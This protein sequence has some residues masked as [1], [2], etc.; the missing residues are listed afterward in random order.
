MFWGCDPE[1]LRALAGDLLRDAG[2][3]A[4]QQSRL[5]TVIGTASWEGPDAGSW[6]ERALGQML[7]GMARESAALVQSAQQLLLHAQQQDEASQAA[8]GADDPPMAEA[9]VMTAGAAVAGAAG[10]STT[11]GSVETGS[12]PV[13]RTR[14]RGGAPPGLPGVAPLYPGASLGLAGDVVGPEY[15][16]AAQRLWLQGEAAGIR[17]GRRPI[18]GAPAGIVAGLAGVVRGE[19]ETG[20][21]LREG[22]VFR[23][24][25]G[26]LTMAISGTDGLMNAA[27]LTPAAPV[28]T[29]LSRVTGAISGFWNAREQ[30]ALDQ[31]AAG[32][33]PDGSVTRMLWELP[34]RW[35]EDLIQPVAGQIGGPLGERISELSGR[36]AGF[37]RGV[38]SLV[39]AG[40]RLEILRF[41]REHPL[42]VIGL[43]GPRYALETPRRTLDRLDL[44]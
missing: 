37:D 11:T 41:G 28:A 33:S 7:P 43:A 6:R 4:A 40:G 29:R 38:E 3:M 22:N 19:Y 14:S 24:A 2:V 17:A 1:A 26:V 39:D 30:D 9:A 23:T 27:E 31:R 25:D 5:R 20:E 18:V 35:D 8:P 10:V 12:G 42:V 44:W 32:L 36:V 15:G 13:P 16:L 21:A 34:Q